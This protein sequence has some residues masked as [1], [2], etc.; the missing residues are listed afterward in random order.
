MIRPYVGILIDSFWEA[1]HNRILWALLLTSTFLLAALAPFGLVVERNYQFSTYDILDRA[2]LVSRLARGLDSRAQTAVAAVAKRLDTGVADK[3]RRDARERGSSLSSHQLVAE[4]NRLL[5]V[6]D[7]YREADFPTVAK[8]ERLKSLIEKPA[9]ER[10]QED[11]EQLN[12]QLLQI[13][14]APDLGA[15]RGEQIW[16]GYAGYKIGVPLGVTRKQIETYIEPLILQLIVQLGLGVMIGLVAIIVT[17]P[18]IPDT[19][20]SGALHLMLSKPISRTW[21]FLSKFAGGCIFVSLNLVYVLTGLYFI[22]GWRFGLWN[23]GLL[24][25]AGLLLFVYV[26]FYSVSALAG[27]VWGNAIVSVVVCIVFWVFC[28]TI[29]TMHDVMQTRVQQ[30][31]QIRRLEVIDDKVIAVSEAEIMSVWNEQH[32]VWQPA[33]EFSLRGEGLDVRTF[34][35]LWDQK[36]NQIVCKT[37]LPRSPF[38]G[39]NH[40]GSRS[41]TLIDLQSI[42]PQPSDA[43]QATNQAY[44]DTQAGAE[45]P[46]QMFQMML[47]DDSIIVISR[48]GI[49]GLDLDRAQLQTG[50]AGL[51]RGLVNLSSFQRVAPPGFSTTDN[52]VAATAGHDGLIVY[53]SGTVSRMRLLDGRFQLLSQTKITGEGSEAALLAA[54]DSFTIVVRE[55]MPLVLMDEQLQNASQIDIPDGQQPKQLAWIPGSQQLAILT[56]AGQILRFDCQNKSFEEIITPVPS[57][58]TCMKWESPELLWL[59]VLPNHVY[60]VDLV[61]QSIDRTMKSSPKTSEKFYNWLVRPL[62]T[63]NP[64]PSAL[65]QSMQYLLTGN[66]QFNPQLITVKLDNARVELDIWQPIISNS[67]FVAVVLFLSCVYVARKEY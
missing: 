39:R 24:Y 28:F 31:P 52:T 66:K 64:K 1:V 16:V 44:W 55:A 36:R 11:L 9:A 15:A 51:L 4:L 32:R 13:T 7:L 6:N 19:F 48:L 67:A 18:I 2:R 57:K 20:R 50:G 26:I 37:F 42:T 22:V 63:I 5:T 65:N 25:C 30:W 47:I 8:R 41:L 33:T 21:L 60:R 53:T 17:S 10:G 58:I 14:L 43:Q 35:P 49:F 61:N 29:G 59:G 56:H 46:E 54:N 27:L 34:G 12:S 38:E 62:Y 3:I 23:P 45:I 40:Q